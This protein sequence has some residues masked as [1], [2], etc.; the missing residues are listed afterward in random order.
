MQELSNSEAV[1]ETADVGAQEAN[2]SAEP[3]A[4]QADVV[5]AQE[6]NQTEATATGSSST[7][8]VAESPQTESAEDLLKRAVPQETAAAKPAAGPVSSSPYAHLSPDFQKLLKDPQQASQL[9]NVNKLYGKQAAE[10]GQL[11][12]Q[13]QAYQ[14]LPPADHLRSIIEQQ[15]QHAEIAKL[16]PWVN[17]HPESAQSKERINRARMFMQARD[18]GVPD[19]QLSKLAKDWRVSADDIKLMNEFDDHKGQIQERLATDFDGLFNDLFQSRFQ[20]AIGQW[21]QARRASIGASQFLEQN[22]PLL[23]KHRDAA[24]WA[25]ENPVRSEVALRVVQLEEEI[26][27]LRGSAV[28]DSEVVHA[29]QARNALTK[30]RAATRRDP[31]TNADTIGNVVQRANSM[32]DRDYLEALKRARENGL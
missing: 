25:M 27:K 14:G 21:E 13:V 31:A 18:A 22:Q 15:K 20:A 3:V 16:K 30:T 24:T 29:A 11:R 26:A 6:A 10:L 9:E 28:K 5:G 2:Q 23:E 12:Q 4:E 8:T 32:S 1:E 7:D 19:E 17:G